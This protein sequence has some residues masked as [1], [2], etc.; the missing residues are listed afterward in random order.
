MISFN[1]LTAFPAGQTHGFIQGPA[2]QLEVIT[3]SSELPVKGVAVICHPH[4]LFQGTMNNKVV[5]TLARAFNGLGLHAVRFNYRGVGKSEGEFGDSVGEITDLMAILN[6]I[7]PVLPGAKLWLAGFSFGAYIAASA[8]ARHPCQQLYSIAPAV[9]HQRYA[10]LPEITCPWVVIQGEADEVVPP[11]EVIAWF[12]QKQQHQD[13]IQLITL[14][15]VTHFF[16][17]QLI[18]LRN[19]IEETFSI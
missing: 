13:N 3:T 18:T 2:G 5:H 15:N 12:K 17:G 9:N 6:W 10:S 8:A 1:T 14:P 19:L 7:D 11:E 4:P 16:H